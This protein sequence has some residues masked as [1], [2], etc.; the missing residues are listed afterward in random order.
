[1]GAAGR[2]PHTTRPE[3]YEPA[4]EPGETQRAAPAAAP[5]ARE[6]AEDMRELQVP[7]P[8]ILPPESMGGTGASGPKYS[9][10][11]AWAAAARTTIP[12]RA[13]QT[14]TDVMASGLPQFGLQQDEGPPG[15]IPD[16]MLPF[17]DRYVG[18]YT[19]REIDY[20]TQQIMGNFRDAQAMA[21]HR[22]SGAAAFAWGLADPVTLASMAI[23]IA[24][25]VRLANAARL[26]LIGG[27]TAATD[28]ALMH[29]MDPTHDFSLTSVTAGTLLSG[30]MGAAI[31][32]H[33]PAPEFAKL[34][35]RLQE[36]LSRP[37]PVMPQRGEPI[38][39]AGDTAAALA[40]DLRAAVEQHQQEQLA[41]AARPEELEARSQAA[42]ERLRAAGQPVAPEAADEAARAEAE[43][44]ATPE[45][46]RARLEAAYGPEYMEVLRQRAEGEQQRA[47]AERES[48]QQELAAIEGEREKLLTPGQ[49]RAR[50][51]GA[52][53]RDQVIA[54][55]EAT[56][57]RDKDQNG[58][59]ADLIQAFADTQGK[60]LG[61]T[62]EA[63]FER[64]PLRVIEGVRAE[65]E[66]GG[67][68]E[69]TIGPYSKDLFGNAV[70]PL[71]PASRTPR[72]APPPGEGGHVPAA[73]ELPLLPPARY[74]TRT[75]II[76]E[77]TRRLG[78]DHVV[79]IDE[80]A[81]A[82]ATLARGS[83]ERFDALV[84]DAAG[85]P[86][87]VVGSSVGS[88]NQ[89][90]VFPQIVAA[91]A[92][93]IPGARHIWFGHNH[94]SGQPALSTADHMINQRLARVFEGS[95]IE[96]HGIF[97]IAGGAEEHG[98]SWTFADGKAQERIGITG[99]LTAEM[100]VPVAERVFVEHGSL[101]FPITGPKEAME[102]VPRIA[103]GHSGLVLLDN[104]GIPVGFLP[105]TGRE[106]V[107]LRGTG[108]M[109]A[110]YRALSISNASRVIIADAGDFGTVGIRNLAGFLRNASTEVMDAIN[111]KTGEALSETHPDP[112]RS[113]E[114]MQEGRGA[115]N[116]QTRTLSLFEKADPSTFLHES[117]HHFLDVTMEI[118]SH[119][120]APQELREDAKTLLDWFGV[121]DLKQWRELGPEGQREHQ[122]QFARGFESYLRD[123]RAPSGRL[124]VIF[125]KFRDWLLKV[126]SNFAAAGQ[127]VPDEIRGVMDRMLASQQET[128]AAR[129]AQAERATTSLGRRLATDDVLRADLRT[130]AETE[131]GWA[132]KGGRVLMNEEGRVTGR[133]SWIPNAEWWPGRPGGYSE[134]E[135]SRI[136][137]KALAGEK[138]GPK[139]QMLVEYMQEVADQRR[140]SQPFLPEPE[141]LAGLDE[142]LKAANTADAHETA[143]V[144]RA[145]VI[146]EAAVET[147][148]RMHEDDP[149]AFMAAIKRFLDGHDAD[150][151][152]ARR[153]PAHRE[154]PGPDRDGIPASGEHGETG[155]LAEPAGGK[156]G[157]GPGFS[158]EAGGQPPAGPRAGG[159]SAAR[160]GDL[161]GAKPPG[162][163]VADERARREAAQ[164]REVPLETGRPD[165]LF[166]QSRRQA[167]LED[168]LRQLPEEK[169]AP[170]EAR[171]R[172]L[173]EAPPAPVGAQPS[174]PVTAAPGESTAG[175]KQ[176][177]DLTLKDLS[178]AR[179][180]RVLGRALG[181][182]AP[183]SRLLFS[184]SIEARR[185]AIELAETP[186][187]LE[188]NVPSA[189]R[190]AGLPT[191]TSVELLLKRWEG[192]W[193]E[194]FRARESAFRD[195]NARDVKP[196]EPAR[197]DKRTWN[198]EVSAAMRRGDKH[199]V[200]EVAEAARETRRLV[201]DP[202][203]V[204][205][206]RLGLMPTQ[207]DLLQGTAESY[208][209]RQYDRAA[210]RAD[211]VNFH[212][213]L[214]DAFHNQGVDYAEAD[215][216]AH[217]V[218]RNLMGSEL[219]LLDLNDT[220]F[221]DIVPQ[222]GRLQARQLLLPDVDLEKYLVNDIDRLSHAYLHTLAPQVEVTKRF[223][224]RS[225]QQAFERIGDEYNVLI[226]RKL[227]SGDNDGANKLNDRL[228]ADIRD[229][230]A[231]RDRM[232]GIYGAPGDPSSWIWRAMRI[233]RSVN[234]FR[235]L[236][237]ATL[238]H[239]PDVAN[240]IMRHGLGNT[241][242]AA[243][244]LAT[245]F[246]ALKLNRDQQ[247]AF[248]NALDMIHN[249]T[250]AQLGE[251]GAESAY[252]TQRLLNRGTRA[253]TIATLETPWI[254]TIKA[255]GGAVAQHEFV[256]SA[257][258]VAAG[259]RLSDMELT[260]LNQ[261]G[262]GE[263]LLRRIGAETREHGVDVNGLR[264]G[265]PDQWKDQEAARAFIAAVD[266]HAEAATLTPSKGD[267]P[268]WTSQEW[269]KALFQFKTFGAVAVRKVVTPLAQGIAHG[270]LRA[271]QGL[272]SLIASGALVYAAK[273]LVSGQ[274]IEKD[275]QRFALE[276][277][278]K[279]NLLGWFGEYFYPS[280]WALGEPSFS[281]WGD[282]QTWETLGGP[283][284]GA[285]VDL[286][287][288]RLP[289]KV[290]G[291]I[292]GP[293]AQAGGRPLPQFSRSDL[294]RLRRLMPANQIWYLRRATNMLEQ[295]VG[296][297]MGLPPEKVKASTE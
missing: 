133:T 79:S 182:F 15:R 224:D 145:S 165:D 90:S 285:A 92:F 29:L 201:F 48:A 261:A 34:R 20:R 157:G 117:G 218:T 78:T 266:K 286:W 84:T 56:G 260:R 93:R 63:F 131:S 267:T 97:A 156:G 185:V 129:A 213:M 116:P 138:L 160:Q 17:K 200:P 167:D 297:W 184:P 144:A 132:Q 155:A 171:L 26:A 33:V 292:Q 37:P 104:R 294:H 194:G 199:Q 120:E 255:L 99:P 119:A 91:E 38:A 195:Y 222:S 82:F 47:Q 205:A 4:L 244:K 173:S 287:D 162:Q 219:G 230:G 250:A 18:L 270:D 128:A 41:A 94:P 60:R 55:L 123:G 264:F 284:L 139:Q 210:I 148:A 88:H 188:M 3:D 118:A 25:E 265:M 85:K 235:L 179:G 237:T 259:E 187:M 240:V 27:A 282:R 208:L 158:L 58:A 245:D 203:K 269:G 239:F 134:E 142:H 107:R 193:L 293:A 149:A 71:P 137:D 35:A 61:M 89:A 227:A 258:R 257:E 108:G 170:F 109:D 102:A 291:A 191:P 21:Q 70:E 275:P 115:Y 232:Y 183:G 103:E 28:E 54:D 202:L 73:G 135:V 95:G 273:Q 248:G 19:Q 223:G 98:R 253:F 161:F 212:Q 110:L 281:R 220:V 206:Q 105:M 45:P 143:M 249:T 44:M 36:D 207:G 122:E 169:R 80:A 262:L 234:V 231:M 65:V 51:V 152:L 166:S 247:Q 130:M 276:V 289:A 204:E 50:A 216:I 86:L 42:Q 64:Y 146:D 192:R 2:P 277:L 229:L 1:M 100:H 283:V 66:T 68:K 124:E 53:V 39:P 256:R 196:G 221:K 113:M 6:S 290:R 274:P 140:A 251:F 214:R 242:A 46:V 197:L 263:D 81:Q 268:L 22:W 30:L 236:G 40:R 31:R 67:V 296:D 111:L 217:K 159:A 209:M 75:E 24:G 141:D 295:K 13:Y 112:L 150:A 254:S 186:E 153:G 226:Q 101:G 136:V 272:A 288:L 127:R 5:P 147:L 49:L 241:F 76:Q 243:A 12:G 14:L 271:V 174:P 246:E 77:A 198:E 69:R 72:A 215:D 9:A 11:D 96:P 151:S 87:A 181:W 238:S 175:A 164:Q 280:L 83:K 177:A 163:A 10:L 74:A 125:Q 189:E 106:A 7:G 57:R 279:S 8:V 32:P 16:E 59:Y 168:L 172:A 121:D 23:P 225:M 233:G 228:K 126:Y 52:T 178:L 180:G 62:G 252:P 211:R 190:P 154:T 114:F 43:R 278:D 176:A